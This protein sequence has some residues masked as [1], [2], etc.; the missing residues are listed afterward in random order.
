MEK[1]KKK[2]NQPK[3]V[4]TELWLV[5]FEIE[6]NARW[7][8]PKFGSSAFLVVRKHW[9][10]WLSCPVKKSSVDLFIAVQSVF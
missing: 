9:G 7:N 2:F 4:K 3:Q 6:K 5:S 8:N 10:L 1:K